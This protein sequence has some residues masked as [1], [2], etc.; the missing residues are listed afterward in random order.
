[1]ADEPQTPQ[2]NPLSNPPPENLGNSPEARNP[3]GSL[4]ETPPSPS[5]TEKKPEDQSTD[6][7]SKAKTETKEGTADTD[8]AKPATGV[9]EKYDFKAPEGYELNADIIAKAEPIFKELNLS[10]DQAQ[11]LLDFYGEAAA[12]AETAPYDEYE[13]MRKSWRDEVTKSDL[14]DGKSGLKPE[15]SATIGRAIDSLPPEI[16]KPFREAMTMTGAGD[17]PAFIRAFYT[18]A[19]GLGEGTLVRGKGPSPAGQTNSNR[20]QSAAT[21]LYPNLPSGAR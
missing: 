11:K 10:Q 9:P 1:M 15:V 17:N 3:D 4:K 2:P 13:T 14:G 18:L 7:K 5:L 6:D 20:P 16:A 12:A 19:Q 21:A 8:K